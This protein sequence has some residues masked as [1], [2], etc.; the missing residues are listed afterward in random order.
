MSGHR[1]RTIQEHPLPGNNGNNWNGYVTG[2]DVATVLRDPYNLDFRPKEGSDLI[3]NGYILEPFVNKW[4]G[5][6]RDIGA[7][8][9]GDNTYWIPGR[10]AD[11]A[12][13]PVPPNGTI[14]A[15]DDCDLMWLE[16]LGAEQH[17][18]YLGS[19]ENSM[20]LV[21]EQTTNIYDPGELD[22]NTIYFWR[23]DEVVNNEII[24]GD[25][26]YFVPNGTR[27]ESDALPVSYVE[28]F[29]KSDDDANFDPWDEN[30]WEPQYMSEDST[31][32]V[33]DSLK[34]WPSSARSDYSNYFK[35]KGINMILRPH[36]FMEFYYRVPVGTTSVQIALNVTSDNISGTP[37][38]FDI[39]VSETSGKIFT[40]IAEVFE[41]WDQVNNGI[42]W[43]HLQDIDVWFFPE[44]VFNGNEEITIDNFS[45]GFHCLTRR[46]HEI[47]IIGQ[48]TI[49]TEAG[50]PFYM[51]VDK[52]RLG[53]ISSEFPDEIFPVVD[54]Y[55]LPGYPKVNVHDDVGYTADRNIIT[56]NGADVNPILV[57][58]DVVIGQKQSAVY[59]F[60]IYIGEFINGIAKR[61]NYTVKIYPNPFRGGF[62]MDNYGDVKRCNIYSISGNLKKS[63]QDVNGYINM[64]DIESGVY[65]LE[66][67]LKNGDRQHEKV[68]KE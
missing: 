57:P 12:T 46:S 38:L 66:I 13:M 36:P 23:I 22:P 45:L 44:T 48:D 63:I 62:Y 61:Q 21:S 20:E 59:D 34:I 17:K 5:E 26:W 39:A 56:P 67:L 16:A 33:N 42:E 1:V 32:V 40:N 31:Y 2:L 64:D 47:E 18:V 54:P 30:I 15:L 43:K 29:N 52:L 6:S 28:D 50:I 58:V 49:I 8:E 55:A 27:K 14:T 68:I 3:D 35:L 4:N 24:T 41:A 19:S 7:Y 10:K 65:F 60:K 53:L 25:T 37:V 9:F 51:S 11:K